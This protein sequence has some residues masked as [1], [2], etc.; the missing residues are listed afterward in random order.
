M[1]KIRNYFSMSSLLCLAGA[2]TLLSIDSSD[3][4]SRQFLPSSQVQ[5]QPK[6]QHNLERKI[7]TVED[8]ERFARSTLTA[9]IKTP[10]GSMNSRVRICENGNDLEKYAFGIEVKDVRGNVQRVIHNTVLY[11]KGVETEVQFDEITIKESRPRVKGIKP[12]T[13]LKPG[14]KIE[15]SSPKFL[16]KY[17]L[18]NESENLI[19]LREVYSQDNPPILLEKQEFDF[20]DK[21]IEGWVLG[22]MNY[23]NSMSYFRQKHLK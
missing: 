9:L 3:A 1:T 13:S 2:L 15:V 6:E 5:E 17:S 14:T 22:L 10:E 12:Y 21:E 4:Y 20:R 16:V 23:S 8:F 18:I 19:A 11:H 7:E